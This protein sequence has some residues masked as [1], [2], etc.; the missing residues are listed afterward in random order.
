MFPGG[1]A[2]AVLDGLVRI[3]EEELKDRIVFLS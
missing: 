1:G 3:L 2:V